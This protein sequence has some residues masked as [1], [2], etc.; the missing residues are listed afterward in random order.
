MMGKSDRGTI[1]QM[2]RDIQIEFQDIG[3]GNTGGLPPPH[4]LGQKLARVESHDSLES[5]GA[6]RKRNKVSRY[7]AFLAFRAVQRRAAIIDRS[8]AVIS[9]SWIMSAARSMATK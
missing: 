4:A 8:S 2:E 7:A 5:W 3:N 6:Q 1:S 9:G